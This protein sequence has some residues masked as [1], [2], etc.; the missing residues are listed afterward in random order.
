[1]YI[2]TTTKISQPKYVVHGDDWRTG[3]QAKTRQR[4]IELLREWNGELIEVPYTH[5]A[6]WSVKFKQQE[7]S[8]LPGKR[9]NGSALF[10]GC[11]HLTQR[12]FIR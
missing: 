10:D 11:E 3:I 12:V 1:M 4:V 2:T 6:A 5:D 9:M 8:H 7:L